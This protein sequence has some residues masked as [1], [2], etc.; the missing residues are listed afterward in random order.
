M[1][2]I[3]ADAVVMIPAV[4]IGATMDT[5]S[6][7]RMGAKVWPADIFTALPTAFLVDL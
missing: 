3:A 6:P 5:T 7:H 4:V 1:W 2:T